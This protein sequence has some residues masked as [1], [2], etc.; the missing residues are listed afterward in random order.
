MDVELQAVTGMCETALFAVSE[1]LLRA[2]SRGSLWM[3]VKL[4][5]VVYS[6][7]QFAL[8][9]EGDSGLL[10]VLEA[11]LQLFEHL[12]FGLDHAQGFVSFLRMGIIAFDI[13]P[14]TAHRRLLLGE[15]LDAQV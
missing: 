9:G 13:E 5:L 15:L 2:F 3:R 14:K 12:V 1:R 8:V 4:G 10:S 11:W 6:G 7:Q